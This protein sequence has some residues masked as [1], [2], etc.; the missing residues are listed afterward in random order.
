[1]PRK[2]SGLPKYVKKANGRYVYRP[3]IPPEQRNRFD[4]DKY[5]Y[6]K[7]PIRLGSIKEPMHK[8][9]AAYSAAAEQLE[10]QK[11]NE[12]LTLGWLLAEYKQSRLFTELASSTQQR[13]QR[14]QCILDHPLEINGVDSTLG[15]L[16]APYL[17]TTTV[18]RILDKRL[19]NYQSNGKKGTSQCN[20]EKA[21]LS[22]LYSYGIQYVDELA[23]MKNPCHGITKFRVETRQRYVTDEEYAIQYQFATEHS[24]SYLPIVMELTYLLAARGVEVTDLTIDSADMNGVL[25]QRRKGSKNTEILW[26]KRLQTAWSK[27]R[28][29]HP[30]N[31]HPNTPLLK[32]TRGQVLT[33]ATLSSAWQDLK[34]AMENAGLGDVY[35]WLHDLKRKGV[36][37]AKDDR[38]AGH[39]S[40]QI[41][42]NYNVK[43]QQFDAP[44]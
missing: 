40:D 43:A 25:V 19:S 17:K 34:E 44:K 32:A 21:L 11:N 16:Y 41:R 31:A 4:T 29:Q 37:D 10:Y 38:I 23:T 13:Y 15:Q 14:C 12:Y 26:T 22:A 28:D 39:V 1:M 35:F 36:T 24:V 33:R 8:I 2:A 18:R 20:N 9:M 5:G 27:A 30:E 6:L 3:Y 7:P 42:A